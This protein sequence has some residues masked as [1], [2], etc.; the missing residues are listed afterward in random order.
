M[1][2]DTPPTGEQAFND[3]NLHKVTVHQYE[4]PTSDVTLTCHVDTHVRNYNTST[5][6][7]RFSGKDET[8]D[9]DTIR[10]RLGI[11]ADTV[12]DYQ[13][14]LYGLNGVCHSYMEKLEP[15]LASST[16]RATSGNTL[17][18]TKDSVGK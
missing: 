16:Q 6:Q 17:F 1:T 14:L 9:T 13:S 12:P 10:Q 5:R 7:K 8:K 11:I 3:L 2:D 18:I 4:S 15:V